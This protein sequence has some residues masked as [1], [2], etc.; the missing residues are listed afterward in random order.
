[1]VN[2][3]ENRFSTFG[4]QFGAQMRSTLKTGQENATKLSEALKVAEHSF[5][6]VSSV[7]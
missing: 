6:A 5:R 1:M 3:M 7:V 2:T 4:L